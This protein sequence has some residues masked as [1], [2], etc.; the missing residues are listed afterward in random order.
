MNSGPDGFP[1]GG[2]G[3][4]F[5]IENLG[6]WG[7]ARVRA[8]LFLEHLIMLRNSHE[9][10]EVD[11]VRVGLRPMRDIVFQLVLCKLRLKLSTMKN[12]IESERKG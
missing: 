11:V 12:I 3:S 10:V 1:F 8:E 6:R 7:R 4:G 2:S 9:G 5:F